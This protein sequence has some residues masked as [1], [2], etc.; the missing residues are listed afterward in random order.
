MLINLSFAYRM[1]SLSSCSGLSCGRE[2]R[3]LAGVGVVAG[4]PA[5]GTWREIGG[6]VGE[7][8]GEWC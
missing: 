4:G 5:G 7:G 2:R 1:Y 3:D 8:I 6:G